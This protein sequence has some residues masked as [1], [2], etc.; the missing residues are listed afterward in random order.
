M[1]NAEVD[2]ASGLDRYTLP[3]GTKVGTGLLPANLQTMMAVPQYAEVFPKIPRSQWPRK[4]GGLRRFM[5]FRW[6]QGV[7]GSCGGH[8][9]T[10][11]FTAKWNE[12]FHTNKPAYEFSPT[13]LYG[14]TNGGRDAGSRPEDL[15]EA[16]MSRGVCLRSTVG[17]G[18][19]YYQNYPKK[20]FDEAK[21]FRVDQAPV[22]WTFE[23]MVS[24]ILRGHAV[25][26]G[27]FCGN[28]FT[29]DANGLMPEWDRAQQRG[30]YVGG[31]CTAQ[32]GEVEYIEGR[33][34]GVWSLN[35][36]FPWGIDGWSWMPES[37]FPE[38][39]KAFGAVAITS[40]IPD[41]EETATV[42]H[43]VA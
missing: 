38:G 28:N 32:I 9:G 29:P 41:P 23:D 1:P 37:Y 22:L 21:R 18:Q 24:A 15:R 5:P 39:L 36:W 17:P 4:G 10:A 33:G 30:W 7:Q 6:N 42:P 12:Q 31:H 20:A 25:F 19:I 27:F 40:V 14:M 35:S 43:A 3:D 8:G 34:W 2:P 13:F 26:S 16:L 11:A